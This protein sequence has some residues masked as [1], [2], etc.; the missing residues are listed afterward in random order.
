MIHKGL[1]NMVMC[2]N[3]NLKI[4]ICWLFL[5]TCTGTG[6]LCLFAENPLQR[7]VEGNERYMHSTTSYAKDWD[8]KRSSLIQKQ[9]P[10]AVIVCCSDSRVPPEIIFDQSLGDLFVI[11]IAGN[12]VDDFALGS[13]EY[14]LSVLNAPLIMV[15]GH[16]KCGAVEAALTGAKFDNHIQN[17]VRAIE[18]AVKSVKDEPADERLEK[19]IKANVRNVIAQIKSAQPTIAPLV[20][21]NSV[22]I[23]GGY[24]KLD[25]GRV[26]L[27]N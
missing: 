17:I 2:M 6:T 18:P 26:E 10:F 19:A 1:L 20:L 9:T 14:A 16:A 5:L 3:R 4:I 24:Y 7:L 21:K 23:V 8:I 15:L 11:R 27:I 12:V 25:S 13:I 22:H